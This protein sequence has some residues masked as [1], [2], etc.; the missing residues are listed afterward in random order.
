MKKLSLYFA[1]AIILLRSASLESSPRED[2]PAAAQEI[3][4]DASA[5]AHPFPHFWEKMFGSGRAILSLRDSYRNDLRETKHITGFEYVRFH[6]IFHYEA[7]L[8]DED[9]DRHP[10]YHYSY[11]DQIYDDLLP[12]TVRPFIDL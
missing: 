8:Y 3:T 6:P 4:V 10:S 2:S 7:G 5:P 1:L 12:N 9:N 11:I